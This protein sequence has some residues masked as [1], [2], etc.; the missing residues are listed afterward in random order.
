MSVDK[1]Y[2]TVGATVST[3]DLDADAADPAQD[4]QLGTAWGG[5]PPGWED[6]IDAAVDPGQAH[7]YVFRGTEYVRIPL[8]T[9]TVDDGY[10]LTTADQWPGRTGPYDAIWSNAP[11]APPSSSKTTQFRQP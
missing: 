6:G 4:W 11:T 8:A 5:L 2:S 9:Q 3:Y 1:A 7:L 10:P